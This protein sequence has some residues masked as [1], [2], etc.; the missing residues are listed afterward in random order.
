MDLGSF[1]LFNM[2]KKRLS[3]AAQRQEILARNIANSDTPKYRPSDVPEPDFKKALLSEPL[4]VNMQQTDSRHLVGF[5][6]DPQAFKVVKDKTTFETAPDGN[7]VVLEEQMMKVTDT[8][9]AYELAANLYQKHMRMLRTA[10]G[11]SGG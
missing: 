9:G 8:K 10:L 1:T 6:R 11:K 4:P 3:W 7:A 2:A 5:R